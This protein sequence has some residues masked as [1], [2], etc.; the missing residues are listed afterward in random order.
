MFLYHVI[1]GNAYRCPSG[2]TEDEYK[3]WVKCGYGSLRGVKFVWA[4][5]KN[6]ALHKALKN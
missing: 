2:M 4:D 1:N 3:E 5:D 6:D